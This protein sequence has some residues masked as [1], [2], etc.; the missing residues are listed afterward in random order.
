V[1]KKLGVGEAELRE[2]AEK[3]FPHIPQGSLGSCAVVANS[4]NLLKGKRGAEI[5]AHDS[6]FRHN[7]PVVGYEE[8]VGTK[9]TITYVKGNYKHAKRG[10]R[11]ARAPALLLDPDPGG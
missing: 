9:T 8:A 7:T 11:Q 6:V 4:D 2:L 10:L 3:Y 1:Q 5:D